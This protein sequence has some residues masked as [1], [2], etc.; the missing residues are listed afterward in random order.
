MAKRARAEVAEN[1]DMAKITARLESTG[2]KLTRS[3]SDVLNRWPQVKGDM[4][5]EIESR[6]D[7]RAWQSRVATDDLPSFEV[8]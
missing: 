8:K 4:D 3:M 2:Q 5:S 6:A 1:W 7:F